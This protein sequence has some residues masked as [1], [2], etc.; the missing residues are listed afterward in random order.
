MSHLYFIGAGVI[1]H[2]HVAAAIDGLGF[3]TRDIRVA[4]PSAEARQKFI[5]AFPGARGFEDAGA[6]L[7]EPVQPDDIVVIATPP[8][9]HARL[10]VQAL[11]SGRHTLCEKPLAMNADEAR[12]MLAAAQ[13]T[14]R[15]LGCCSNRL[16]SH[17]PTA[18]ARDILATG[19]LGEIYHASWIHRQWR[20]RTGIEY[21]PQTRWFLDRSKN[22]G[23]VLMDWGPYDFTAIHGV[24]DPVR[25]TTSGA[26]MAKPETEVDPDCVND[27]EQAVGA[28]LSY[29]LANGQR[30]NITFEHS[31][32]THGEPRTGA[33][34]VGTRGAL[35]WNWNPFVPENA[36]LVTSRDENGQCIE[37]IET[38]P[39]PTPINPDL[40]PISEF[41]KH[42]R[43]E[44]AEIPVNE[45]AVFEFLCLRSIYDCIASGQPQTVSLEE[46]SQ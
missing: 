8:A 9:L 22:G 1:T 25:L 17:P 33:E 19:D 21:Q 3:S 31:A 16:V 34:I 18:R 42:L 30:L 11:H 37:T 24:F 32:C 10:T 14:G 4:D 26:W 41:L 44:A 29:E 6:M 35:R 13:S 23:G 28:A 36:R 2:R 7:A 38:V 39:I 40:M 43:G 27:V 5:A 15:S 45:Q 20:G 12:T 46:L